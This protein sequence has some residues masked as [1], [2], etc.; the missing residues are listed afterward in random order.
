[1]NTTINATA[2]PDVPNPRG[3]WALIVTQ[4][5]GAFSDNLFKML[6]IL[7]LPVMMGH[8]NFPIT[9]MAFLLFNIPFL[10]FP[11]FA[12]SLADKLSKKTVTVITKYIELAVMSMGLGGFFLNSPAMILTALFL[13]ASQSALFSPAKYGILPE[14]LE[15]KKLSWGNG[16]LQ[17]GTFIAIIAGTAV[18]G[19][20]LESLGGKIY[21]AM[22]V[23]LGFTVCGLI[24][25]HAITKPAPANPA[26]KISF[27]PWN[28]LGDSFKKFGQ[29]RVLFLTMLGLAFFWFT[30][31]LVSQTIIELGKE[32]SDSPT[33]QSLLLAALSLG[34]GVG[35]V[36]AGY[37]SRGRVETG[38]V[39]FGGFGLA[40]LCF[41][42][43]LGGWTYAMTLGLI[44]G[45]GIF[46]G[47]FDL[48]L[49]AMLQKR[50]PKEVKGGMIAASNFVTFSGMT[51][52]ALLFMGLF[53][54]LKFSPDSIFLAAG[55]MTLTVSLISA[56]IL[57][58]QM[59]R[60]V[61]TRLVSSVYK[62]NVLDHENVPEEGGALIVS[63]HVSYADAAILMA[64]TE[65]PVRFMMYKGIYDKFW[66]KPLARF[67]GAIPVR[68][69]ADPEE[70]AN[71]LQA[72][73]DAINAGEL[74]VI[75]AEGAITRT[76]KMAEFK[77]GLERIM[78]N[79]R[80]PIVPVRLEGLW[81]SIFSFSSG[82][83]FKKVPQRFPYPISVRF[84]NPMSAASTSA[85]VQSAVEQLEY[86]EGV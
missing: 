78:S 60:F 67:I 35:S 72:A 43:A 6:V 19:P 74:V 77:R 25:S 54:W 32:I 68:A 41:I 56:W 37:F 52:A 61:A 45:L 47:I 42:L 49:A 8:D 38:M 44:F 16:I 27:N 23:L 9:A 22:F 55:S 51:V 40:A 66:M 65:R 7:Y 70:T 79:A 63:N 80:G 3:F 71:A 10:L 34:I 75:F 76:G 30:G 26:R 12:G 48:P 46:A 24:S 59:M 50:S 39:P 21:Y 13:M 20:L 1:M 15:D 11:G 4:F 18:A 86:A 62:Q 82:R 2:Q 81:G 85:Q 64:A 5:Q 57:R 84:G 14:I 31:V 29:D 36:L 58:Q 17:L 53:N 83:F 28:G 33:R 73:T 69:K